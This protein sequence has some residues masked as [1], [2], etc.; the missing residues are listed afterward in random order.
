MR[1]TIRYRREGIYTNAQLKSRHLRKYCTLNGA[2][3]DM[4]E[5]AM[6]RLGLSAR[7]HGRILRV[8]RTIADLAGVEHINTVHLAEAIQYRTLDRREV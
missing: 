3:R 7:A 8:A 4:L 1:Q 5:Q 6:K 2:G